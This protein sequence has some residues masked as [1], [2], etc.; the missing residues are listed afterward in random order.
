[1]KSN[2]TPDFWVMYR[3]LQPETRQR[4]RAAYQLWRDNPRHNSLQFK[5]VSRRHPI[6]SVR[7]GLDHRALGLLEGDTVHWYWIGPHDEYDRILKS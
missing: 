4:A 5:R 2:A 1:M 3:Q 7:V 6:Y